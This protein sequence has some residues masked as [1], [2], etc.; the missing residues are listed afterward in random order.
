MVHMTY[1]GNTQLSIAQHSRRTNLAL[2]A[3]IHSAMNNFSTDRH[4]RFASKTQVR[5]YDSQAT[6]PLITFDSGADGHYLSETDRL[7]AGL[8]I[9]R[10]SSGQVGVANG[11][12]S[13]AR[14]VSRL[15][16]PQL[17]SNATLADLFD[18]FPQ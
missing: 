7:T 9:L 11:G 12:T 6:T 18:D 17:S 16:F 15:P 4:V 3:T 8:P 13:K 14:Y 5:H 1:P 10:P 2:S